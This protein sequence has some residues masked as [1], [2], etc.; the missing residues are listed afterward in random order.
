MIPKQFHIKSLEY[1]IKRD[2]IAVVNS[3]GRGSGGVI[4][5]QTP[6]RGSNTP[7]YHAGSRT[8]AH[9]SQTPRADGSRTPSYGGD[10]SRTPQYEGSQTPRG[11][12]NPWSSKSKFIEITKILSYILYQFQIRQETNLENSIVQILREH[13]HTQQTIIKVVLSHL[14]IDHRLQVMSQQL[15]FRIQHHHHL[16][17]IA[18]HHRPDTPDQHQ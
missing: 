7:N 16:V 12:D 6:H 14:L 15:H 8:P 11:G 17:H 4:T 3:H 18:Q 2:N 10:G 13:R 1:N 9:G 5:S